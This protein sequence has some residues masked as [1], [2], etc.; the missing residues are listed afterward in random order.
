MVVLGA[1]TTRAATVR[2]LF[3]A[4]SLQWNATNSLGRTE[5][6]PT[7]TIGR[8]RHEPEPS[9]APGGSSQEATDD[10]V[11]IRI[12]AVEQGSDSRN[13][14]PRRRR[15]GQNEQS[16]DGRRLPTEPIPDDR[17]SQAHFLIVPAK[18]LLGRR[19][20]RLEL[21]DKQGAT[22]GVPREQVNRSAFAIDRVAD[23]G[24]HR[25][26]VTSQDV[27]DN[28]AQSGVPLV[29][30]AVEITAAPADV[31]DDLRI[32]CSSDLTETAE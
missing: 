16:S 1:L 23:L 3:R 25:P 12:Y 27:S 26:A 8:I 9:Q 6:S 17:T 4:G 18:G 2:R 20:L 19:E 29:E 14:A 32:Q 24:Q 28:P 15:R 13:P 22:G 31:H 21:D 7:T 11:P 30:E 5:S 10:D